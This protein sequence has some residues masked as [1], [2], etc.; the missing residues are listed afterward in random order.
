[1]KLFHLNVYCYTLEDSL[2]KL[3]LDVYCETAM[4]ISY[5]LRIV[6]WVGFIEDHHESGG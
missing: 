1:M 6:F 2:G 4:K 3:A 5:T